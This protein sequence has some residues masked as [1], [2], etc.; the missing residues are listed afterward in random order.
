MIQVTT[1]E[2]SYILP[3]KVTAMAVTSSKFGIALQDIIG[4][5]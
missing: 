3:F 5:N 2:K 4:E 1:V